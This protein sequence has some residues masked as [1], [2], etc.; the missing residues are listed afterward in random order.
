MCIPTHQILLASP[1]ELWISF[2][3]LSGGQ[4]HPWMKGSL[5]PH[6]D[7]RRKADVRTATTR[8]VPHR[9]R[10]KNRIGFF[11]FSKMKERKNG[12]WG[13]EKTDLSPYGATFPQT[14]GCVG[15]GSCSCLQDKTEGSMLRNRKR[16]LYPGVLPIPFSNDSLGGTAHL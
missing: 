2:S 12:T 1:E 3:L 4:Q 5:R 16:W 13:G 10:L 14:I 11:F 6:T 8:S 7:T 15:P 9:Q